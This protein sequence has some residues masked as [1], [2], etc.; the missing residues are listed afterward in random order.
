MADCMSFLG[1]TTEKKIVSNGRTFKLFLT[2]QEGGYWVATVLWIKDDIAQTHNESRMKKEES[3]QSAVK[4][5]CSNIDTN[6][7]V[8][9]L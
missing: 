1:P 7:T 2:E 6:A 5:I 4:W 9:P 8:E 3:Y